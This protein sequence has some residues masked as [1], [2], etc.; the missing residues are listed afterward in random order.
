[1][2]QRLAS[3]MADMQHVHRLVLN[4]EENAIDVRLPAIQ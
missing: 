1:M 3:A 4:R 2:L